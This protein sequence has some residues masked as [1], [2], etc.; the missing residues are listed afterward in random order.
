MK[1][2]PALTPLQLAFVAFGAVVLGHA[3]EI[4]DGFY[5]LIALR[6]AL[7]AAI[8]VLA[9]TARL[10]SAGR[11]RVSESTV[12]GVLVAGLLSNF[13]ALAT[14]PIGMYLAH[15]EP[16]LHP[17]FLAGLGLATL[18]VV[19][20]ASDRERARSLW[21]PAL[22]VMYAELGVWLIHA[23]PRPHIDVMTVFQEGLGAL[24]EFKSPYSITFPNIYE[25]ADLYGS[26]L[27][28]N[29]RVQFGFPYPPL[30]LL[31]AAPAYLLGGDVRYAELGAL[32]AGAAG[33][34]YCARGRTAPLAAAGLLFTPR[35]FFVLEQA[36][37]ESLVICWVGLTMFAAARRR[38]PTQTS[39]TQSATATRR[40]HSPALRG[41]ALG[42][43]VAVKQHL[44]IALLFAGWLRHENESARA[45]RPILLI[46]ISVAAAVTIPFFVWDPGGVWRSVVLLQLREPFRADS[47][48]V[49]S[50]LASRGWQP[51]NAVLLGAPMTALAAGLGLAWWRLPRTPAGFAL[52]L[53]ATFL[54]L[55]LFSKKAFC[56]YYFL[57]IALLMAGVAAGGAEFDES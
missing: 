8:C 20:I 41:L 30:S 34:G 26:G 13:L 5:D 31:M 16:R 43:L 52:G 47:L 42:L 3:I 6:W 44:V 25:N 18:F 56:N 50:Y 46:A 54:L 38:A 39:R 4:R 57:V 10:G 21:F 17:E 53:G 48:S 7:L 45:R 14:M 32:V 37:T 22:L 9:G 40:S 15:P 49:L 23:S 36:W 55:F 28:V 11:L 12:A 33:I 1:T 35:T 27:V 29:G 2:P 51:T 19:L 24:R